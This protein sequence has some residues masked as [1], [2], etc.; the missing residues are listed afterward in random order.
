MCRVIQAQLPRSESSARQAARLVRATVEEWVPDVDPAVAEAAE[1]MTRALVTNA[2]VHALSPVRLV[3][4]LRGGV[5]EV[6]VSDT[7][8]RLPGSRVPAPREGSRGWGQ[9]L[10]LVQSLS[11]EWGSTPQRVGKQ[12]WFTL[13]VRARSER[14]SCACVADAPGAVR[15][16]SGA[17]VVGAAMAP[18]PT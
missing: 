12:V 4:A 5:L 9:G 13:A 6:G 2:V 3:I 11:D 15:L 7:D 14:E 18:E 16:G 8:A 10:T 1:Q 17:S